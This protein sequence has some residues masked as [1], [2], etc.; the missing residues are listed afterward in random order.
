MAQHTNPIP[1]RFM[2]ARRWQWQAAFACALFVIT[3]FVGWPFGYFWPSVVGLI[4]F[5]PAVWLF[6]INCYECGW[7]CQHFI[8]TN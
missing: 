7:R 2:I 5:L 8:A 4:V 3:C 1:K 6:N